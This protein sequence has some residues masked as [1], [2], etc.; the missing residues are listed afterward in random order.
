MTIKCLFWDDEENNIGLYKRFIEQS[1]STTNSNIKIQIDSFFAREKVEEILDSQAKQYHLFVSDLIIETET[2]PSNLG[3]H[4]IAQARKNNPDM[5][6]VALTQGD[7]EDREGALTA[8]ADEVFFKSTIRK[9]GGTENLKKLGKTLKGAVEKRQKGLFTRQINFHYDRSNI[10]LN[11]VIQTIGPDN[12]KTLVADMRPTTQAGLHNRLREVEAF[13]LRSGLSGATVLMLQCDHEVPVDSSPDKRGILLKVSRDYDSLL[14]ERAKRHDAAVHFGELFPNFSEYENI[15]S[16]NGWHGLGAKFLDS[17]ITFLDWICLP[18]TTP[19][20]INQTMKLLFKTGGLQDVYRKTSLRDTPPHLAIRDIMSHSHRARIVMAIDELAPV[21]AD[22]L[23]KKKISDGL[24]DKKLID[25]FLYEDPRV[26]EIGNEHISS[27]P[28]YHNN[29]LYCRN[30]GDLHNGNILVNQND[31]P[32]LIDPANIKEQPWMADLARFCVDLISS[33]LDRK[34]PSYGWDRL[35]NWLDACSSFIIGSPIVATVFGGKDNEGVI[36]A[37]NWIREM[38]PEIQPLYKSENLEWQ[39]RLGLAVEFLR[40]GYRRE[41]QT[42]PKRT[43]GL[44]AA[45]IALRSSCEAFNELY[46]QK[47]PVAG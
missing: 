47:S 36:T 31:Q 11:A 44:L 15:T 17:A 27:M 9:A 40:A 3:E 21:I 29:T 13:F 25:G 38:L 28:K 5:G 33:G 10:K 14:E 4:L 35:E 39:F 20:K 8:G 34:A 30:H 6:I 26:W 42:G 46:S 23:S 24:Y 37:L 7:H 32:R 22:L 19:E 1:W 18:A 2:G 45:C 16:S 41:S 12:I 43:L